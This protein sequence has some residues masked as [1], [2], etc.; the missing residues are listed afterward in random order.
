M[1]GP[2]EKTHHAP[3]LTVR[4]ATTERWPDLAALWKDSDGCDGCW[5][6]NH[7]IE[8]GA[9]DVRGDEAREA[10]RRYLAAGRAA[11]V[12]GYLDDVPVGWCAVDLARNLPGHDCVPRIP[13]AD[14]E[15]VWFIHCFY[16]KPAARGHGVARGMLR[17][18]LAWLRSAG[19][20]RVEAFPIPPEE[21]PPF[22]AFGG[23]FHLYTE[24]GFARRDD[25]LGEGYCRVVLEP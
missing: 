5:C 15:G 8:R 20:R 22:P 2:D 9:A 16:V 18:T 7:H 13:N 19:A 21:K 6:F 14:D 1:Q 4:V 25:V 23:P 10:K 11:G 17:G 24:E 3:A 12:I